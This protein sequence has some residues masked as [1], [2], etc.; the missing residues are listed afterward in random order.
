MII[1]AGL[2]NPG[3]Q[4]ESTRHN[5]GFIFLDQ[6]VK[7]KDQFK[8]FKINKRFKSQISH[9]KVGKEEV[10][11]VKPQDFY[12]NSGPVISSILNFYK[13]KADNLIIIHDD[14]DIAAGKIRIAYDSSAAGNNGI[15][16]IIDTL[17]SKKF[18]R[19]RVGIKPETQKGDHKN[20]VLGKFTVTEK[21]T[22]K[23]I[24]EK[25]PDLVNDLAD[26]HLK[27]E[28]LQNKYN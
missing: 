17:K 23:P 1:I 24:I 27:T 18:I 19:V 16:S 10:L 5:I 15:Q 4:Y 6:I 13:T 26:H 20:F 21:K 7:N 3:K 14:L 8:A 22:I 11:L 25:L 28:L 9:G 12:N 2:G